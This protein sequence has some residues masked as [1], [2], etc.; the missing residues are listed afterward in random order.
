MLDLMKEIRCSLKRDGSD[1]KQKRLLNSSSLLFALYEIFPADVD[2]VLN[3][4][5]AFKSGEQYRVENWW[6]N[7]RL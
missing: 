5:S 1:I 6:S 2:D 7:D 4:P 3:H